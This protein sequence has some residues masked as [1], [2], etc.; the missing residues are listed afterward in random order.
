MCSTAICKDHAVAV[1]GSFIE[2]AV[3]RNEIFKVCVLS[4]AVDYLL[5]CSLF[6]TLCSFN[7]GVLE[8][9]ILDY[10]F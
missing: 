9:L 6:S 5:K 7:Y 2:I 4:L 1:F 3:S 8:I 10:L